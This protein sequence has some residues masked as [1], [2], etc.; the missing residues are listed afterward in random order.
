MA[1]RPFN[2]N[3]EVRFDLGHG[4]I[5]VGESSR[6][7]V[8]VDALL[9]LCR[10]VGAD[11]VR[12]FGHRLGAELGRRAVARLSGADKASIATVVEHFGGD[13]ALIGLGSLS[14]EQWGRALVL[15]VEGSPLGVDGDP[16]LG[17]VLEGALQRGLGRDATLVPIARL[18]RSVRFL[19]LNA[20]TAQAVRGWL[21]GGLGWG[22]ALARLNAS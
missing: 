2:P 10:S 12:D 21:S 14:A 18:D 19:V 9:A 13:L 7:F 8:P 20:K 16:L 1:E 6:I 15:S 4:N 3:Q 5:T 22:D 11:A 17:A